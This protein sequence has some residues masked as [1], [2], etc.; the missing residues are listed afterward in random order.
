MVSSLSEEGQRLSV[1]FP[2]TPFLCHCSAGKAEAEER[3]LAGVVGVLVV[4]LARGGGGSNTHSLCIGVPHRS[5]FTL[6]HSSA[7]ALEGAGMDLVMLVSQPS[8]DPGAMLLP[9]D[10]TTSYVQAGV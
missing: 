10:A 9:E 3:F 2:V 5:Q 8:R 6:Q 7:F 4:P 1:P